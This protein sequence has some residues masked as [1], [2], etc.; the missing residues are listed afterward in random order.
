MIDRAEAE[1]VLESQLRL[2]VY[3]KDKDALAKVETGALFE[4]SATLQY[5]N[6]EPGARV[7]R[8]MDWV[9]Y[10]IPTERDQ[11][12]YPR[13]FT[14]L[15]RGTQDREQDRAA[16]LYYFVQA[17]AGAPWKAA[18]KSWA[19]DRP[20]PQLKP[21]QH[22]DH[23]YGVA[24]FDIR[25]KPIA[26]PARGEA[27]SAVLSPTAA[28]DRE[29][30][31]RYAEYLSFTAPDGEPGSDHFVPGKLTS[32][33]VTAYNAEDKEKGWNGNIRSRFAFEA[34]GVDLP[35]LR[36]ADG[37]SLVTCTFVQTTR[38]DSKPG[39]D[40]RF[41]FGSV[42][43]SKDW[44][45]ILLGSDNEWWTSTTV[46]RSVTATFEVPARGPADVVG[47]NCLN[48]PVLSA[49]GSPAE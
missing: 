44:A 48:P 14:A 6:I 22:E 2:A 20:A 10:L 47:C 31:G 23:V 11:P 42:R 16:G 3:A 38:T 45:G 32:D 9:D 13:S 43:L 25:D 12:G 7:M 33:I 46:R 15:F 26:A 8:E 39:Q 35:V 29:V 18:A 1:K 19:T 37:K 36:L 30:C 17:E 4:E 27:G 34:T 5:L 40:R 28:G 24:G 49:E 41:T 21:G